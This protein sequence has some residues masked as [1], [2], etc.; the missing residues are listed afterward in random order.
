MTSNAV[1]LYVETGDQ[2]LDKRAR[3]YLAGALNV[4]DPRD[5]GIR[6]WAL[7]DLELDVSPVN[8][9]D[10]YVVNGRVDFMYPLQAV[11]LR[12][13]GGEVSYREEECDAESATVTIR[14]PGSTETHRVTVRWEDIKDAAWTKADGGTTTKPLWE[15]MRP[16]MLLKQALRR[17]ISFYAPDVLR[18]LTVT[19]DKAAALLASRQ[20]ALETKALTWADPDADT[21]KATQ[22]P[23]LPRPKADADT[24]AVL[25]ARYDALPPLAHDFVQERARAAG[26]PNIESA[27]FNRSDALAVEYL[28]AVV[29]PAANAPSTAAGGDEHVGPSDVLSAQA[30]EGPAP[31]YAD[32]DPER[33]FE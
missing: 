21:P 28:L 27:R 11:L 8:L 9:K 10:V 1:T 17:A 18:T 32:D 12:R 31:T 6:L 14:P 23:G 19:E 7:D 16:W 2:R 26:I 15:N 25:K 13:A 30:A 33:P 29:T 20:A 5:L 3:G 22:H 4:G 24:V